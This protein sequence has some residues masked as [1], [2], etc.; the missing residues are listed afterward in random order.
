[1]KKT[2]IIIFVFTLCSNLLA[3]TKLREY[4]NT[5]TS[6]T[7]SIKLG[8]E[9]KGLY[10]LGGTAL[11]TGI[12]IGI[13]AQGFSDYGREGISFPIIAGGL[14][15]APA[16]LV[17]VGLGNLLGKKKSKLSRSFQIGVGYT[18][19]SVS[20]RRSSNEEESVNEFVPGVH[21][22]IL[23]NEIGKW[24]YQLGVNHF[25][26][27]TYEL[28]NSPRKES[29]QT[30]NLNLQYL[31]QINRALKLYP[32]VGSQFRNFLKDE[33]YTNFGL[34][35][36]YEFKNRICVYGEVKGSYDPDESPSFYSFSIGTSYYLK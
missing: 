20:I 8:G 31:F 1:M 35:I 2:I 32:F 13:Y 30:I 3:E 27:R 34:G 23:S 17:G 25:F 16:S 22:K 21:F 6:D 18:L 33:L 36:H 7:S 5:F 28:I 10:F 11:L 4:S 15:V 19:S 14:A 12:G 24:R 26:N 29:W 9:L